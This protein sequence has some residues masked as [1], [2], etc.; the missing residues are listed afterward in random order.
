MQKRNLTGSKGE[1]LSQA[2]VTLAS[3]ASPPFWGLRTILSSVSKSLFCTFIAQ[4]STIGVGLLSFFSRIQLHSGILLTE[5]LL[6]FFNSHNAQLAKLYINQTKNLSSVHS[7]WISQYNNPYTTITH[8]QVPIY[9]LFL[10]F[11]RNYWIIC[12]HWIPHFNMTNWKLRTIFFPQVY[13]KHCN[14]L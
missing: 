9:G 10:L 6:S 12:R 11:Y 1:K 4:H 8:E 2:P 3:V 13:S 7:W 14:S 5:S